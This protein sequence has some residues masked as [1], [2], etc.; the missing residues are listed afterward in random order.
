[1]KWRWDS[2]N[3]DFVRRIEKQLRWRPRVA[4]IWA[5]FSAVFTGL[6][7]Y[8]LRSIQTGLF[9]FFSDELAQT[10]FRLGAIIGYVGG[11]LVLFA[12]CSVFRAVYFF[13]ARRSDHLFVTYHRRLGELTS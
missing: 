7:I 3:G 1:M 12:L 9:P 13:F 6:G 2:S 11:K 5:V 4:F 8:F 10:L